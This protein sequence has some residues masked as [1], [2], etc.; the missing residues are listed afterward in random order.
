MKKERYEHSVLDVAAALGAWATGSGPDDLEANALAAWLEWRIA[1]E[2]KGG[3]WTP[4]T[5]SGTGEL[6]LAW[7]VYDLH[8]RAVARAAL[9]F[10]TARRK[11]NERFGGVARPGKL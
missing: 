7:Q 11:E 9:A 10:A 5:Y 8:V 1:D 6:V 4:T 3:G 2:A